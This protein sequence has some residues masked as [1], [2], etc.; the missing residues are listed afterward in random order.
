MVFVDLIVLSGN[1]DHTSLQHSTSDWMMAPVPKTL[2]EP[3]L[4][5]QLDQQYKEDLISFREFDMD[6]ALTGLEKLCSAEKLKKLSHKQRGVEEFS[7]ED[8]EILIANQNAHSSC[9]A[10]YHGLENQSSLSSKLSFT[11]PTNLPVSPGMHD[12]SDVEA[13]IL[14]TH[15]QIGGKDGTSPVTTKSAKKPKPQLALSIYKD[16]TPSKKATPVKL[17]MKFSVAT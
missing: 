2:P 5:P 6:A 17:A 8:I 16:Y 3:D 13:E 4:Y 9:T 14:K 10:G 7:K 15:K 1:E 12:L 11:S